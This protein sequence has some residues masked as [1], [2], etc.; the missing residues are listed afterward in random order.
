M[1]K[2]KF[3]VAVPIIGLL[4][5][6]YFYT[7][8]LSPGVMVAELV[9][10]S[11][12]V[13]VMHPGGE[14]MDGQNGMLLSQG[15]SV[16]TLAD[17]EAAI[18]FLESSIVRLGPDTEV[19]IQKLDPTP[20]STFILVKQN[21]G[22]TWNRV[23]KLSGIDSYELETPTTVASVRGTGF[24]VTV[25]QD[26]ETEVKLVEGGLNTSSYTQDDGQRR[27]MFRLAIGEGE[28]VRVKPGEIDVPLRALEL[29]R[30][31]FIEA[32]LQKD[33]QFMV[34]VRERL[35]QRFATAMPVIRQTYNLT[36]EQ[37]S[38]GIDEYLRTGELDFA[39]PVV[40]GFLERR[41]SATEMMTRLASGELS[42]SEVGKF[43]EQ[44][45]EEY[46][47]PPAQNQT[48]NQ[49]EPAQ[50]QTG[51]VNETNSTVSGDAGIVGMLTASDTETTGGGCG[52]TGS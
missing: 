34:Q 51:P 35:L 44:K 19:E 46:Q 49:T 3:L 30:D 26:G 31:E 50:N 20:D 39:P 21:Y 23:L 5:F 17:S 43:I 28:M 6:A 52:C 2:A 42:E 38:R 33:E 13:Q 32:S 18:I 22:E 40:Q 16:R 4:I 37:V 7:T 47:Q 27:V 9:I 45:R 11:G 10:D 48:M 36:D 24:A 8:V 12:T 14:W 25:F 29:M 41:I 1:G 15:D